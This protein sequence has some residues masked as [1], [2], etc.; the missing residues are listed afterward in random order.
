MVDVVESRGMASEIVAMSLKIDRVK[1]LKSLRP[2]WK[3]GL[4]MSVSSGN[5]RKIE[6]DFLAVNAGFASG[7]LCAVS[8]RQR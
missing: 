4:L 1:K 5:I 2:S 8:A 7:S 3:V 6:A